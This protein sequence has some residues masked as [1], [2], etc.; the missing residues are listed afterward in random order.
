[1]VWGQMS[2]FSWLSWTGW[3][4]CSQGMVF[5]SC[6]HRW[7]CRNH[8]GAP[9]GKT[10]GTVRCG[11]VFGWLIMLIRHRSFNYNP[12]KTAPLPHGLSL[13]DCA[14]L[15]S[16]SEVQE[17]RRLISDPGANTCFLDVLGK[18]NELHY[19]I[20][21]ISLPH[22]SQLRAMWP[23]K[24]T[25]DNAWGHDWC[26][27]GGVGVLLASSGSRSGMLPTSYSIPDS[28]HMKNDLAL[29]ITVSKLKNFVL[30]R[31]NSG[32][33]VPRLLWRLR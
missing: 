12:K 3:G 28:S 6:V 1:M 25:A 23:A 33:N 24:E 18:V 19:C 17:I 32:T 22:G 4:R 26:H 11:Q 31:N 9:W 10:P 29:M 27:A 5:R 20:L 2:N 16:R 7:H 21:F 15:V 30:N 8:R 14:A 13:G